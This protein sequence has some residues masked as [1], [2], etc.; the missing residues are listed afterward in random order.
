MQASRFGAM[1]IENLNQSIN[2]CGDDQEMLEYHG[3]T[4]VSLLA[5]SLL[6]CSILGGRS[7]IFM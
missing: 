1:V 6:A 3:C 7:E 4:I 5:V 2:T